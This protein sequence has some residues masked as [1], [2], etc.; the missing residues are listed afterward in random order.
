MSLIKFTKMQGLGNDYIY[1]DTAD[2]HFSNPSAVAQFVSDRHLGVGGDGLVLIE[3]STLAD[4][5]MRIFNADGSEA[6][7]CGNA[8][9]CVGKYV[10]ERELTRKNT[11][12]IA[13]KSG[14]KVLELDIKDHKV[15][16]V[17]V[18][19]GEPLLEPRLIP[20]TLAGER[21]INEPLQVEQH[22]LRVTCV[23]MGNPHAVFFVPEI[24][25]ELVLGLGPKIENHPAFPKR[26]NVE[27]VKVIHQSALEMRVWERGSGET[28]ACGTGACAVLVAASLNQLTARK[29]LIKLRGGVLQVAWEANNHVFKDGPAVTVFDGEIYIPE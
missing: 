19:M 9:R 4:F 27:F 21:I 14:I 23:S 7:M 20:T 22:Q 1:V 24:T 13:T 3:R 6:E 11:L 8:I 26:T 25:D 17:R 18:D 2:Y 15:Q 29:A 12:T 16:S 10:Y 28:L 5:A